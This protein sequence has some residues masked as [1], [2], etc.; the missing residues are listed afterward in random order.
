MELSK[1]IYL[2]PDVDAIAVVYD[3]SDVF[4][5]AEF[6]VRPL[7]TLRDFHSLRRSD[8]IFSHTAGARRCE[9]GKRQGVRATPIA[10]RAM[11]S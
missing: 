7:V 8:R 5:E 2:M 3:F 11:T 6:T 9:N 10:T 4:E 1:S